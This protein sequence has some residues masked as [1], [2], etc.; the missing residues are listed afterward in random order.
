MSLRAN[1]VEQLLKGINPSRVGKDGKGFAHLEAW[2]VRA[3]LI[4][5]F[6][7][8]KWSQELIE[9]EPIFET[10][11]EKDGKT[12]WTVAYRA[13]VRLTI[14]TGDLED[15]IYTEAAVGDSQNN[16]SRADAHDMAIKTAESQ[17]FKRCAIN[18]GDQF[19]LSLYNNGG[20]SSVVR[21]V[22]DS[23]QARFADTKAT[24]ERH[25]E[26]KDNESNESNSGAVPQQLKR[27]N[28]LG[29][30]VTDGSE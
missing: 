30:P 7:F 21:A 9:L 10:S 4:R 2:D 15:A 24:D 6:G 22:L 19:G 23:E 16:P 17:A 27:V 5:I 25:S 13:T 12:R 8:A 11:I 20:T 3:H 18:L 14:Y 26:R 1:Q 28:I 29:K